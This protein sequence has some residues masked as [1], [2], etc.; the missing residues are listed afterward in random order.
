MNKQEAI[1]RIED[2]YLDNKFTLE[3]KSIISQIDEP[4]KVVVPK[5]IDEKIRYCK[6]TEGYGL[7]HCMDYCYQYRDSANWLDSN[8]ETL[9]RAWFDGYEVKQEQGPLYTVTDGNNCY[10]E[11]WDEVRAIIVLDD[12][13]GYENYVKKFDS[14]SEAE[15][16]AEQ[17]GWKVKEVE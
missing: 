15:E 8:E 16:V 14:K 12:M 7:F 10:F 17:L 6:K 2:L 9:A 4:A 5:C 3:V 13:I 1:K 11:R